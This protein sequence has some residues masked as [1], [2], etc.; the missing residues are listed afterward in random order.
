MLSN[1]VGIRGCLWFLDLV[2][3]N[4][5]FFLFLGTKSF[6]DLAHRKH[7]IRNVLV[8]YGLHLAFAAGFMYLIYWFEM[9]NNP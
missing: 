3:S 7:R 8:G 2:R 1:H 6:L 4:S 9:K 5:F